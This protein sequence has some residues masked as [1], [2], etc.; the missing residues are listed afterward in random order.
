MNENA[1]GAGLASL[2]V[3]LVAAKGLVDEPKVNPT[4][5]EVDGTL[6]AAVP[7]EK[8]GEGVAS[9]VAGL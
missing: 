1:A 4:L 2:V 3:L 9:L 8:V 6:G 5:P 7:K